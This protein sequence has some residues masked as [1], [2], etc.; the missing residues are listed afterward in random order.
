MGSVKGAGKVNHRENPTAIYVG[1]MLNKVSYIT[2]G[3]RRRVAGACVPF[4]YISLATRQT[5]LRWVNNI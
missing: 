4:T 5:L 1:N 3:C 2:S